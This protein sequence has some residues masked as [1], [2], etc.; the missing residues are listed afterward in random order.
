MEWSLNRDFIWQA[1]L[2]PIACL[3]GPPSQE[4]LVGRARPVAVRSRRSGVVRGA[5][6]RSGIELT[7]DSWPDTQQHNT[8]VSGSSETARSSSD[9][10]S[11]RELLAPDGTL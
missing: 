2:S 7:A 11:A 6:L 1:G 8:S 4:A 10:V 3:P 9:E 5:H